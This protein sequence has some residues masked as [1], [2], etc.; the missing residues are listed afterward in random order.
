MT[1]KLSYSSLF[2]LIV[3]CL[4]CFSSKKVSKT[5][6]QVLRLTSLTVQNLSEEVTKNDE[7]EL[8]LFL[9]DDSGNLKRDT[10]F[11][12]E[13]TAVGQSRSVS[14]L[15]PVAGISGRALIT[16]IEQDN[17][18]DQSTKHHQTLTKAFSNPNWQPT[19]SSLAE[20]SKRFG[21]DDLLDVQVISLRTPKAIPARLDFSGV[22][23]F[24]SYKYI[25][26]LSAQ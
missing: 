12:L 1:I 18:T 8:H 7:I 13:F 17:E 15:L 20:L 19:T 26:K 10:T 3:L 16:L 25:L 22:H 6:I 14:Y 2:T 21:D 23:L 11:Q 9:M 5:S 24:D 4:G